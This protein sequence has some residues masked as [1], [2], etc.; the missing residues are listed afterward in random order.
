MA[1][2]QAT[3]TLSAIA[4]DAKQIGLRLDTRNI[5]T[6]AHSGVEALDHARKVLKTGAGL[7]AEILELARKELTGAK[8]PAAVFLSQLSET[9]SPM[10]R[11]VFGIPL[12]AEGRGRTEKS[13]AAYSYAQAIMADKAKGRVVLAM[14]SACGVT[15][16]TLQLSSADRANAMQPLRRLAQ[17]MQGKT[18]AKG[19]WLGKTITS[20]AKKIADGEATRD[21]VLKMLDAAIDAAKEEAAKKAGK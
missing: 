10:V 16:D 15:A 21:K 2:K 19:D 7:R 6:L 18:G 1:K 5:W 12:P 20:L 14:V 9:T 8:I 17:A 13:V 4:S 3:R 11:A